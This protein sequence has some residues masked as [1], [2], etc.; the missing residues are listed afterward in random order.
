MLYSISVLEDTGGL[1]LGL[2]NRTDQQLIVTNL[3]IGT[4]RTHYRKTRYFRRPLVIL[5]AKE[6]ADEN[7]QFISSAKTG[8]RNYDLFSSAQK[9]RRKHHP[10]FV[11]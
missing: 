9:D 2:T 7:I 11:G 1:R 4:L 8:G 5:S 6:A 10:I 3:L